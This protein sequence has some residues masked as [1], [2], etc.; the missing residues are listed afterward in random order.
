[1]YSLGK[2]SPVIPAYADTRSM[3][4]ELGAP[5]DVTIRFSTDPT[6]MNWL[7]SDHPYAAV[8]TPDGIQ[9][10]V[11][12][13]RDGDTIV[14]TVLLGNA[15]SKTITTAVGD[16]G[17][18]LPLE[19]RY[20]DETDDYSIERHCN[21][22]LFCGGTCSW[23]LALRMSGNAPHLGLVLTEGALADYST[24]RD[25]VQYSN[26]RGCFVLHPEAMEFAP[27]QTHTISWTI[28]P[29]DSRDDFF[30][31][32]AERSAFIDAR[33]DR[34]VAFPGETA[35]LHIRP[36]FTPDQGN[37]A[38]QNAPV[39][40]NGIPA[41]AE[42]DGTYTFAYT[43][44]ERDEFT[45]DEYRDRAGEHTF[46]VRVGDRTVRTR[47]FVSAPLDELTAQRVRFIAR[48]QQYRGPDE[49]LR[50]AYLPYDNEDRRQY[51]Y[52]GDDKGNVVNDYNA[53]RE[54][55]GMGLLLAAYLRELDRGIVRDE[56]GDLLADVSMALS[57]D[58]PGGE[59]KPLRDELS[60]SLRDY[61]EFV[62][63]ELVDV[64]TG[65]VFNDAPRDNS[66]KRLYNAPWFAEL[67]VE[68]Y[69]LDGDV[70][71]LRVACRI[72]RWFYAGGGSR[73]YPL[74]LPVL[75]L[76]R[77]LEQ[78][79]ERDLL[80]EMRDLFLTHAR[81]LAGLGLH[82]PKHEV[83][84]EQSIVAPAASVILQTAA[85]TG[86]QD[87]LRAGFEQLR[88]LDQF[89]GCQPDAH[90]NEVAIR[91]WD[92]FWFGK[93]KQYGDT[94]PHYW[95]GLTADVFDLAADLMDDENAAGRYRRRAEASRRAL[96]QLFF[97]DGTA[98]C[99][100]V[101]P[102]SVNGERTHFADPMANDQ[103]WALYFIVRHM[104]DA[105]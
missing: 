48:K 8:S 31:Q 105:E 95:S 80:D 26:D 24:S 44:D 101:F 38:G 54:R 78:A 96:L 25:F 12:M 76:C 49:H 66:V 70:E 10:S 35:V 13:L 100:Y 73:F 64:E 53:G 68:L 102:F 65:E 34:Y 97:A 74:E 41:A 72:L 4:S 75:A 5:G 45:H 85:L 94:F 58:L 89:N 77:A 20:Y 69:K 92:G 18:T 11:H 3:I 47:L 7:R 50:G 33:W 104:L 87:L 79:D 83:N 30:A 60:D 71:H 93:R 27:G 51:Y 22:H 16:I 36:S 23:A 63:R 37:D 28:F 14:T 17:I 88:V 32:A 6:G 99:A 56:N 15:T 57:G 55:V 59:W 91:H 39:T 40:V 67:Y 21:V 90:L 19:D 29:C 43:P 82:Y 103:D 2:N 46:V 84:Y 52:A 81:T 42:P 61:R 62:E 1:M 98:S 9:S 86:D